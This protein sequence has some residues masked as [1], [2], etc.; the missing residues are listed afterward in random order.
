M[1]FDR[2]LLLDPSETVE[3]QVRGDRQAAVVIDGHSRCQLSTGAIVRCEP[4]ASTADFVRFRPPLPPGAVAKL[5]SLIAE[6]DNA[7]PTGSHGEICLGGRINSGN[8]SIELPRMSDRALGRLPRGSS[9]I[10]PDP[11]EST[12]DGSARGNGIAEGWP[13][14][15]DV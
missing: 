2:S 6:R 8:G 12:V 15:R 14:P 9:T 3:I 7:L 13:A 1:L 5:V 10:S 11:R 4:S